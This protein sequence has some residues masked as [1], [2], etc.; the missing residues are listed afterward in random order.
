MRVLCVCTGNTCRSPMLAAL[1]RRA[2]DEAGAGGEHEVLSA[3]VAAGDG[4]PPSAHAVACMRERGLDIADHRSRNVLGLGVENVDAFLV[5]GAHHGHALIE[6]GVP[7]ER[8]VVVNG[9]DGGV[10]DPFGGDRA[11][12]ERCARSLEAA[13]ADIAGMMTARRD[14]EAAVERA[15]AAIDAVHRADPE[16]R[17]LAYADS[18]ERWMQRLLG[19]LDPIARLA[20]RCQH[21]ERWAIPRDSYP[22]DRPGYLKWRI[23]VHDRQGERAEAILRDSG[24]DAETAARVRT[25]VAKRDPKSELGQALEDAACLVFLE[26]QAADFFAKK[27]YDEAKVIRIVQKTWKKMSKPAR[28][29]A[30]T[31]EMPPELGRLVTKALAE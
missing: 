24:I 8:V 26:E 22:M 4:D 28:E 9:N 12:Y 6:A 11:A 13:A 1:L 14:A 10:P 19:E 25:L 5:M 7:G 15:V 18:V 21:L 30:G 29:L 27:A 31:I 17:E 20:A 16:G 23:A 2:L 3:G